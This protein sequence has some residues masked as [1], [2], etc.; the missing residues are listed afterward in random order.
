MVRVSCISPLA[1][2]MLREAN[3]IDGSERLTNRKM[4]VRCVMEYPNSSGPAF[5]DPVGAVT[6]IWDMIDRGLGVSRANEVRFEHSI[7][8]VLDPESE[9]QTSRHADV[10]RFLSGAEQTRKVVA[11]EDPER[12]SHLLMLEY[13]RRDKSR[14]VGYLY[15][16]HPDSD[17]I[18]IRALR[19]GG[20]L[21]PLPDDFVLSAEGLVKPACRTERDASVRSTVP[22]EEVRTSFEE[23]AF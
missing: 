5:E 19:P 20:L 6:K 15:S 1:A 22:K 4:F 7:P 16:K 14:S 17:R 8:P 23:L 21:D 11:M 10:V 2:E 18:V 13:D 3:F 12:G 9:L